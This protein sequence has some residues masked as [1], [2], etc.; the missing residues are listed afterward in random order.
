VGFLEANMKYVPFLALLLFTA[1]C[2]GGSEPA[3]EG[4]SAPA[5][6][7]RDSGRAEIRAK[8]N[9]KKQDLAQADADLAKIAAEREQLAG[10]P[11]SETKTNRLVEL[12]RLESD[13]KLRKSAVTEDIADLQAQLGGTGTAAAKKPAK[14]GDA[15]DDILAGNENK[16]KEEAERRKQKADAEAAADKE[17]IAKA[18]AARNA[19]L[20]ER[21][22][23]KIEGGRAG[24]GADGPGFEERWA[25]VITKVRAELQ[26]FKR[27]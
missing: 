11:A 20:E 10:Q 21:S 22:K 25:D 4:R 23:Q 15:L 7:P 3:P 12:A 18:E 16:E 19:E 2:G 13:A 5:A 14:A 9:A 26:R 1:A 6:E 27:W 24:A 8:I 17:R